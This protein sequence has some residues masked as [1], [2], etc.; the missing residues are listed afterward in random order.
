MLRPAVVQTDPAVRPSPCD[1]S[2]SPESGAIKNPAT[3]P[4][5]GRFAAGLK[6][7]SIL[8]LPSPDATPLQHAARERIEKRL[9]SAFVREGT[10]FTPNITEFP[11]GVAAPQGVA[12]GLPAVPSGRKGLS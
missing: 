10:D 4:L 3:Q 8:E 2:L 1:F 12:A 7:F 6:S 5:R 11:D 9:G